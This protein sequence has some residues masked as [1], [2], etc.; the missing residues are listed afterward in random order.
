MKNTNKFLLVE[1][2]DMKNIYNYQSF[3]LE[4]DLS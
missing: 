2:K 4:L 3:E 1:I